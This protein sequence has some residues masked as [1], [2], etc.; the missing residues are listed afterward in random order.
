MGEGGHIH[1]K[2]FLYKSQ[3]LNHLDRVRVGGESLGIKAKLDVLAVTLV[4]TVMMVILGLIYFF[5]TLL[6]VKVATD[7]LFD[8]TLD[9]NWGALSAALVTAA[10]IISGALEK[11]KD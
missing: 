7:V 5:L 4:A 2:T 10:V 3:Y 1:R 6:I 8:E 9:A 11:K